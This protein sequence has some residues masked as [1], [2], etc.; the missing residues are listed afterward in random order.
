MRWAPVCLLA[1]DAAC[2]AVSVSLAPTVLE[3]N[4]NT[5]SDFVREIENMCAAFVPG[6]GKFGPEVQPWPRSRQHARLRSDT[7]C[8]WKAV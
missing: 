1:L 4:F 2:K 5:D 3:V 6:L 8:T 7:S